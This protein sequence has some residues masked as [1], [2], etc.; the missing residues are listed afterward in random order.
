V[1]GCGVFD[2]RLD[3]CL[4]SF[5]GTDWRVAWS[6]TGRPCSRPVIVGAG[7]RL[8][9]DLPHRIIGGKAQHDW[10]IYLFR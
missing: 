2:V 9:C 1:L 7:E 8:G 10:C 4:I 3:Y 5:P 6:T